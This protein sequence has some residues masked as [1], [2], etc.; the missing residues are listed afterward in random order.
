MPFRLDRASE[1]VS[2]GADDDCTVA[3]SYAR[4]QI[5]T[6][7][8]GYFPQTRPKFFST[9][10]R[11]SRSMTGR[12]CGQIVDTRWR[13]VPPGCAPFCRT[14][15]GSSPSPPH[16]TR[17]WRRSASRFPP[18]ARRGRAPRDPEPAHARRRPRIRRRAARASHTR[19]PSRP[20]TLPPRTRAVPGP[21]HGRQG[22]GVRQATSRAAAGAASAGSGAV[23][24]ST[25][26]SSARTARARAPRAGR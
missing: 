13:A 7:P 19:A 23:P 22:P 17:S 11:V 6:P 4:G 16:G 14:P 12:P 25:A 3:S 20:R 1:G 9:S 18:P 5:S 8:P 10:R 2:A 24:P 26:P 21:P 15:A